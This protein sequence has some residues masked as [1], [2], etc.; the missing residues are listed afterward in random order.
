MPN[1]RRQIFVKGGDH[2]GLLVGAIILILVLV[3]VASGLFYILANRNLEQATYRAHFETLRNTMQLLLPWL[4]IVNIVALIVVIILALFFTHKI[5][6][7]VYHLIVDLKKLK[8][9]DL[10]VQTVFRKGDRF[11]EVASAMSE[12]TENLRLIV[13]DIKNDVAKISEVTGDEK[14]VREKLENLNRTLGKLKT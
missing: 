6:G 8:N 7:P 13:A 14:S 9:G 2:R 11:K 4:L 12:T 10:T 5:A 1:R 3:V